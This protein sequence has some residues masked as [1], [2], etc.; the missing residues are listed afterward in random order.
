MKG[1]AG[2][3]IVGLASPAGPGLRGILRVSGPHAWRLVEA[4]WR[5][6]EAP[7]DRTRRGFFHG[8]FFD[9]VGELPLLLLWMPGPRSFTRSDLPAPACGFLMKRSDRASYAELVDIERHFVLADRRS[10]RV[11]G[12][13]STVDAPLDSQ[14][15]VDVNRR[16][17]GVRGEHSVVVRS[18]YRQI[19]R[20][21]RL[22]VQLLGL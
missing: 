11:S 12:S 2:G 8:R 3:T 14:S 15:A 18:L 5:G 6:G 21:N 13:R 10:V 1:D 17:V 9:G 20:R 16:V 7:P 22:D 19:V 4:V